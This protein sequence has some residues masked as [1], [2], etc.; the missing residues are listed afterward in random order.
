MR[1]ARIINAII[2]LYLWLSD[3]LQPVETGG[4]FRSEKTKQF[5]RLN[6]HIDDPFRFAGNAV[7]PFLLWLVI[8]WRIRRRQTST[9]PLR[10]REYIVAHWRGHLGLLQSAQ[11]NGLVIYFVLIFVS[12]IPIASVQSYLFRYAL[13]GVFLL[14]GIWAGVGIL[15]CGARN[16]IDKA[17]TK[18]GELAG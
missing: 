5:F 11:L 13:L 2:W 3:A 18:G 9:Q 7:I 14:W 4:D 12:S 10:I 8:D 15:R 1:K 16:A 6:H 17:N